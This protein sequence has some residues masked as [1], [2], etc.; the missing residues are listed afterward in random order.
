MALEDEFWNYNYYLDSTQKGY[1]TYAFTDHK[2][3]LQRM[4]TLSKND[5]NMIFVDDY[6]AGMV[7]ANEGDE[8]DSGILYRDPNYVW[9]FNTSIQALVDDRVE[10]LETLTDTKQFNKRVSRFFQAYYLQCRFPTNRFQKSSSYAHHCNQP[11]SLFVLGGRETKYIEA[12]TYTPYIPWHVEY[13]NYSL[14]RFG[15]RGVENTNVYPLF[16]ANAACINP[17]T[18]SRDFITQEKYT[19]NYLGYWLGNL[20][21]SGTESRTLKSAEA[22]FIDNFPNSNFYSSR[23]SQLAINGFCYFT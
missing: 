23:G 12:S 2:T 19:D 7:A 11:D 22:A 21:Q 3:W 10:Q 14:T 13:L 20:P 4:L 15:N 8:L 9:H 5:L 17:S 6:I 18:L 1:F 16:G